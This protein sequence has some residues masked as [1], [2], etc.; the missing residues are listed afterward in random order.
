M[1][2]LRKNVATLY[3]HRWDGAWAGSRALQEHARSAVL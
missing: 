3:A 2:T 1:L